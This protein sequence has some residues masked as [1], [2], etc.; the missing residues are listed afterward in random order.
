MMD[1][2]LWAIV[3]S[4]PSPI[5]HFNLQPSNDMSKILRYEFEQLFEAWE[6]FKKLLRRCPS[7]NFEDWVQIELFYNG[8]NGQTRTTVDAEAG[9]TIFAKSPEQAYEL[10]EQMTI[11]SYQWPSE[12]AGV[13]KQVGMYSVDPITSLTTQVSVLASQ[14]AAMNKGG[15]IP[16]SEVV[17]ISNEEGPS[18][19]EAQ[20]INNRGY[21][22]YSGYRTNLV[23][24]QYHPGLRNHKNFSYANNKNVLNPPPGFC[25]QKN[26][27]K[28]SFEDL[29]STFV[30]ES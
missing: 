10:L 16:P 9:G 25:T 28:P 23:P 30:A 5:F 19:E 27:G 24:N 4:I 14:I 17:A 12:R 29:V 22:G 1:S 7:H 21:G 2:F 15:Q 11:N 8:L 6:R 26:E 20:Y 18:L 13:K 3:H